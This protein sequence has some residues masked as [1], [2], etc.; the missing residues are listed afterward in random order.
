LS[1]EGLSL[2]LALTLTSFSSGRHLTPLAPCAGKQAT[3]ARGQESDRAQRAASQV[4]VMAFF[5][6][7]LKPNA[8]PF[9]VK[10][11]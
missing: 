11:R 4:R 5:P 3:S 8:I 6:S 7:N 10:R 2:E 9:A 1:T